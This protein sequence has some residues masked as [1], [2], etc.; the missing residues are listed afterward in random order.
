MS[1][2]E[3]AQGVFLDGYVGEEE[4]G[5]TS[6]QVGE[7]IA[8]KGDVTLYINSFGGLAFE[9][10][11]IHAVL[12]RHEG[13]VT[14][15][16]QGVALSAASLAVMAAD[17]I[18][19][20][21]GAMMM[22]HDPMNVTLGNAA[23]HRESAERLDKLAD[24]YARVYAQR[25]GHSAEAVREMMRKETWMAPQ[26]AV[27]QG[28]A[29][30]LETRDAADPVAF[31]YTLFVNTPERLARM[32]RERGWTRQGRNTAAAAAT[33]K[34]AVMPKEENGTGQ[35]PQAGT[36]AASGAVMSGANV[37]QP[38]GGNAGGANTA[39]TPAPDI[40]VGSS[41][42]MAAPSQPAVTPEM[43]A[44]LDADER[45]KAVMTIAQVDELTAADVEKVV[46]ETS[47]PADAKMKAVDMICMKRAA[48]NEYGTDSVPNRSVSGG[49]VHVTRD[50]GDT[51]MEGV[52]QALG[53][54]VFGES[55]Y[56]LQNHPGMRY[57][58]L[59]MYGLAEMC[60][61]QS[62]RGR[63]RTEVAKLGMAAHGALMS[64]GAQM[65]G[66][67]STSDFGF[68]TSELMNRELRSRYRD[69]MPTYQ[70]ISTQ[71]PANDF[72][73]LHSVQ[74]GGDFRML[75]T[76]EAGEY[77][78]TTLTDEGESYAV[79]RYGREVHLTFELVVNDDMGALAR[80]P[81][82]FARVARQK[83]EFI[84]WGLILA[85]NNLA[86]GTPLFAA[87]RNNLAGSGAAISV[88]TVGKGFEAMM[89][90]RPPGA[91]SGA[92]DF[93]MATPDTL[94][95]PPPQLTKASQFVAATS[96]DTD[97]N[98]NPY[99]NAIRPVATP[100]IMS[101]MPNGSDTAWYL[102]DSSLPPVEHSFLSGYETPNV[103]IEEKQNPKGFTYCAEMMFGAGVVEPR[104]IY[105]NPGA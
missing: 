87:G 60:A 102:A 94:I 22:I 96:P 49:G 24:E 58:G 42:T 30:R 90:Q 98:T 61:G 81:S 101:G 86:D 2:T 20:A 91:K 59:T 16:V 54:S 10:A 63:T 69:V 51:T 83:E 84:V 92:E 74:F 25:S 29:D 12:A 5:F 55:R 6:S 76:N 28:F 3:T 71:R 26:D 73:T 14:C 100:F 23:E 79:K 97:G 33:A 8:G 48:E 39:A 89:A 17:E 75:P 9:G 18:A 53:A 38:Q 85:N 46:S 67:H 31:D 72:R 52:I 13:K 43:R 37:A 62:A 47:D 35:A 64:G 88:S 70:V 80:L 68:L 15:V 95:V 65:M 19:M 40:T 50:E 104:G 41:T 45:R 32:A 27:E 44:R 7:A 99:K 105:K 78:S 4:D 66:A 57:R 93:V 56:P 103:E 21:D 1:I 82:E 36:A 11:A 34:E 77:E